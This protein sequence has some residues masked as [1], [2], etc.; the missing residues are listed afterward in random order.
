MFAAALWTADVVGTRVVVVALYGKP[1]VAEP[2]EITD[3]WEC[4]GVPIV[5]LG[6]KRVDG[7]VDAAVGVRIWM[8][9][10]TAVDGAH[11]VIIAS[12]GAT[13]RGGLTGVWA[14]VPIGVQRGVEGISKAQADHDNHIRD[15]DATATI[16]IRGLHPCGE[17]F[18]WRPIRREAEERRENGAL[19]VD[20]VRL[21]RAVHIRYGIEALGRRGRLR[22]ER[23]ERE[24]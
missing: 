13:G 19:H 22:T 24:S 4:A 5:A 12:R 15:I 14:A 21:P 8:V 9:G 17:A 1:R 6:A 3:V 2:F 18:R 10:V 7:V 11:I 16:H 20:H 23:A